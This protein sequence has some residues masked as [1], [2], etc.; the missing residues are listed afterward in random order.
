M[1]AMLMLTE[2]LLKET[3]GEEHLESVKEVEII[4]SPVQVLGNLHLMVSLRSLTCK[5]C[6]WVQ[7]PQAPRSWS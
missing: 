1:A 7:L 5:C 4:F 6:R 2:E 3:T